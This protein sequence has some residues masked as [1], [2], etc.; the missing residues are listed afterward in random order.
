[1][2]LAKMTVNIAPF[3]GGLAYL[4]VS[5]HYYDAQI[6]NVVLFLKGKLANDISVS[7]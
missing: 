4:T 7:F 2:F 1:M 5:L 6:L 3:A